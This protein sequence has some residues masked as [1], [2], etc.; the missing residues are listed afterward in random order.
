M[1]KEI[2][3]IHLTIIATIISLQMAYSQQNILYFMNGI[4]QSNELNP[5][6]QNDSKVFVA[7]PGL[8]NINLNFAHTGFTYNDLFRPG[9]GLKKD[10]LIIDIDNVKGKLKKNNYI[11]PEFNVTLFGFGFWVKEN[12]FSFSLS[13]KLKS[14]FAYPKSLMT[15]AEG[16]G[17]NIGEDNPLRVENFGPHAIAYSELA[18]G[19]SRQ[20]D[21]K[22]TVGGKMKI[23]LGHLAVTTKKTDIALYTAEEEKNYALR[24]ETDF[25]VSVAGAMKVTKDKEGY[26]EDVEID[27]ENIFSMKNKGIAF[28]LGA[29]Y[30]L[31][32]K[33]KLYAS[34]TDLG[35]IK[36]KKDTHKFYQ[37]GKF[38]FEGVEVNPIYDDVDNIGEDLKD[39]IENYLQF[40]ENS[41]KF[42]TWLGTNIY[43]GGTYELTKGIN[44]GVLSKTYFYN[45]KPH[46][47][48]IL[49]ANFTPVKWF[50][51][52]LSYSMINRSYSNIGLG[53]GVRLGGMQI[54]MLTDYMTGLK[55]K[56]AKSMGFQLGV[57]LYFGKKE[58]T[59]K[60]PAEDLDLEESIPGGKKS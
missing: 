40:E 30:Q 18:F 36:W 39:S 28:D 31:N 11:V 46:Q 16:N 24:L 42:T 22:L 7:F 34:I 51:G 48:L 50:S 43:L 29:T 60:E 27:E 47:G 37:K 6:I 1:K 12:Y 41:D 45:K 9:S 2:V 59:T 15:L 53:M 56:K 20:I 21:D 54:Y 32:D 5:A 13:S 26:V 55:L 8:S 35:Y 4:Q 38:N 17:N 25:D 3:K 10:S 23:L 33:I 19:M 49:S 57:N 44:L 58:K 52:T 14:Y